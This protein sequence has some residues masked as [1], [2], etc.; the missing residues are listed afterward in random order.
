MEGVLEVNV[1][2]D[3]V[4]LNAIKLAANEGYG[5][6]ALSDEFVDA[7]VVSTDPYIGWC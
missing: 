5:V 4:V 6:A 7:D 3:A 1:C 2:I